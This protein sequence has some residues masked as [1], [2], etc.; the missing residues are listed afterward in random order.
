MSWDMPSIEEARSLWAKQMA[1][2]PRRLYAERWTYPQFTETTIS[3]RRLYPIDKRT[4][5][6]R[7]TG[8]PMHSLKRVS[9]KQGWPQVWQESNRLLW[10]GFAVNTIFYAV[11]FWLV[12]CGLF[13]LR[14][15]IRARRGLCP[16]CAYPR[17]ESTVCSECG[18][19]LPECV[20]VTT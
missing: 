18:K 3:D 9:I 10:P 15:F 17:G 6:I 1:S 11:A 20:K 19:S 5:R 4:L 8:W 7:E 16:V 13:V 12:I 14:R 2:S